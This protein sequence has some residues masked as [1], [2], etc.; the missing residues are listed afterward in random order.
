[1]KNSIPNDIGK[2]INLKSLYFFSKKNKLQAMSIHLIKYSTLSYSDLS[3][4][5]PGDIGKLIH[6]ET[7]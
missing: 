7:L 4:F 5:I 3:G 2:L 6:L 1:M